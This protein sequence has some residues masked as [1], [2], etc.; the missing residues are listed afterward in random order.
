MALIR[1]GGLSLFGRTNASRSWVLASYHS[2]HS[3]TW[4]WAVWFS[5]RLHRPAKLWPCWWACRNNYGLQ[6]SVWIPGV[7]SLSWSQQRP[8]WYRDLY[9]RMR[10]EQDRLSGQM[11]DRQRPEPPRIIHP[12]PPRMQ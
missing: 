2:P 11:V 10:D 4:R 5:V 7:C 12:Q 6:W 8:I 1:I 9:R 3:L